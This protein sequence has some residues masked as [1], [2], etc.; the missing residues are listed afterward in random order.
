[1]KGMLSLGRQPPEQVL[2]V[3]ECLTFQLVRGFK[4]PLR[5]EGFSSHISLSPPSFYPSSEALSFFF[6]VSIRDN[7]QILDISATVRSLIR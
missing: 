4:L 6:K 1:M 3:L 7:C 2:V 5:S